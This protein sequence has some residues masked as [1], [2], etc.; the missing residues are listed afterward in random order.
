MPIVEQGI[1]KV[2]CEHC[3]VFTNKITGFL[4][5][6][7]QGTIKVTCEHSIYHYNHRISGKMQLRRN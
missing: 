4:P 5:I 7:K 1:Y 6:V 3:T 2:K